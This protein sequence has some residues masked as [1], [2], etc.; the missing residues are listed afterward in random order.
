MT[1]LCLLCLLALCGKTAAAEPWRRHVI[2]DSSRGADGVRLGDLNGDGR[3]DVVTGW[4]EGG[5]VRACLNPEPSR[6]K[7]RWPGVTLGRAPSPEDAVFADLDGDGTLD[8]ISSCE[9][10]TRTIFVHW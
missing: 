4:E 8:A 9:G 2:D 5:A 10:K 6:A 3:F 1:R 7:E